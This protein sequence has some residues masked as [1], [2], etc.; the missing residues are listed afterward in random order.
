MSR[1]RSTQRKRP[2]KERAFE[3]VFTGEAPERLTPERAQALQET[4]LERIAEGAKMCREFQEQLR[5]HPAPDL[6]TLIKLHRVLVLTL[7][8]DAQ[9]SPA[10]LPLITALMKPVMDWARL[11]EKRKDRELAAARLAAK[12][13]HD[14]SAGALRPETIEKIEH[15]LHLL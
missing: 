8:A 13:G 4:L 6:E 14:R 10:L 7:S 2:T 3:T 5:Q 11:E 1:N 9:A 15:E 12:E